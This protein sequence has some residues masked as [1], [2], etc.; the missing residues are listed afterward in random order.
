MTN[1]VSIILPQEVEPGLWAV[2][3]D[4][5]V[6]YTHIFWQDDKEI[7]PTV[8]VIELE[9]TVHEENTKEVVDSS[10]LQKLAQKFNQK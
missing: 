3:Q 6:I 1:R 10:E 7:V 8:D 5:E 2:A 9:K 4:Q